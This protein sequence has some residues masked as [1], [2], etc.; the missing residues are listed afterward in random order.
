MMK[1][2]IV[3]FCCLLL[4]ALKTAANA[5]PSKCLQAAE[6]QNV[7]PHL[8]YKKAALTVALLD[9][10]KGDIIC[11]CLSDL[12]VLSNTATSKVA[13]IDHQVTLQRIAKKNQL[14][15]Q[16]ILTLIRN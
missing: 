3:L 5:L 4:I 1:N 11:I 6:R 12:K 9:V 15:G 14:S 2:K 16:D 13:Q 10:D 8:I 7:C